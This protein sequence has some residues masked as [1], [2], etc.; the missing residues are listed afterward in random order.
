[1]TQRAIQILR[2]ANV[3]ACE[4]TRRTRNL[5]TH[6]QIQPPARLIS[7]RQGNEDR[8]GQYLIDLIKSGQ[9]VALCSDGGCPSVSD[10]GY[11]L[12]A[13]ALENGINVQAIP[14]ASASLTALMVSGLPTSSFTFKGYPPKKPGALR[15]FLETD[16]DAAHT[17]IIYESPYRVAKTL[18]AAQE[19]LGNRRAA[20]CIE[21]TKKFESVHRGFL[22]ELITAFESR[23]IK[24]EVTIVIAGL[25]EKFIDDTAGDTDEP[26]DAEDRDSAL[27]D[28]TL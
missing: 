1:M 11:R 18:T 20:V 7:Y 8:T 22:A 23:N 9:T 17:L 16:K 28:K 3:I 5:L 4:D 24:G 2:E 19:V 25:H 10:P 14:G 15:R 26:A 27:E 12:V 13:L 21:L 6:F